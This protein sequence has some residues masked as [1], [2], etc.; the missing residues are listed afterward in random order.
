MDWYSGGVVNNLPSRKL[1][2]IYPHLQDKYSLHIYVLWQT[3]SSQ[4][5]CITAIEDAGCGNLINI[6]KQ[7]L[8]IVRCPMAWLGRWARANMALLLTDNNTDLLRDKDIRNQDTGG[9]KYVKKNT[10]ISPQTMVFPFCVWLVVF[11]CGPGQANG[12]IPS[13]GNT[14]WT[15]NL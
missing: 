1:Q 12:R 5:Y 15:P 4:C 6:L 7:S 9:A 3:F 8:E 13:V 11:Q 2:W 14:L 10:D